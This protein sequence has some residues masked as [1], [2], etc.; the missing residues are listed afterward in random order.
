ME[1]LK[2]EESKT[3]PILDIGSIVTVAQKWLIDAEITLYHRHWNAESILSQ[4]FIMRSDVVIM[5]F[6]WWWN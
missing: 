4:N 6:D 2:H 1:G 5:L 3:I